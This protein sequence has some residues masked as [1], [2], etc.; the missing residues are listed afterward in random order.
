MAENAG[1]TRDLEAERR[2]TEFL[3]PFGEPYELFPC[4]PAFADT[5]AFCEKYNYPSDEGANCIVVEGK[6]DP[7]V[8]AACLVLPTT[9]LDVNKTVRRLLGTKKA[10]FADA[11][12]TEA[13]TGMTVGGVTPIGLPPTLP[14]YIDSR[15]MDL[16]RVLVGGGSRSCKVILSP[17]L[18][19]RLPNAQVVEGLALPPR[20][21][22]TENDPGPSINDD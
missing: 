1:F 3:D 20:E 2:L 19:L 6:S 12:H 4:D 7:A 8:F 5:A 13:F 21:L 22:V 17:G 15:I 11:A 18:L 10:S 9:R 14:L 16:K